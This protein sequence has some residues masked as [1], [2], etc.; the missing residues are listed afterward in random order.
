[1]LSHNI[2]PVIFRVYQIQVTWYALVYIIG[3]LAA[4]I[5]LLRA[6]RRKET[7]LTEG[8]VYDLTLIGIAGLLIGARV[9]HVL[10][11]GFDYYLEDWK[12]ILYFW[13]GGFSFHGGLA[14][15]LI[16]SAVY[17]KI[18]KKNFWKI[19]DI[20]ALLGI[21]MPVFSRIANFINQEIVGTITN[22]PWCFKFKY[23]D[24]CRHPVQL[25]AAAGRA[26]FFGFV[27][28]LRNKIGCWR[29]GF[30]FWIFIFGI[31][32][33]RFV[34]DFWRE[35]EIYYGLKS[36]QWLSVAMILIAAYYLVAYYEEDL[37]KSLE[38]FLKVKIV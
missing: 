14:G 30:I 21:L 36:G 28:Q 16:V 2:N 19:V 27:L 13:R 22:V 9:F 8:E 11:W 38:K 20:L 37:K 29:E 31:G 3:F 23:N 1:M 24:G 5:V 6:S 34:L 15:A 18:K 35:D 32:V 4:L 17:C 12:R 33:G 7:D 25:Y 26:L 10:F